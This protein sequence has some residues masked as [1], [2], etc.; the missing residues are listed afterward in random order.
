MKAF[1]I[2]L[3]LLTVSSVA[4]ADAPNKHL[5]CTEATGGACM[6]Q[7]GPCPATSSLWAAQLAD[8]T[9]SPWFDIEPTVIDSMT[10]EKER[11]CIDY[12]DSI[13]AGITCDAGAAYMLDPD[14]ALP[15]YLYVGVPT[16][17]TGAE[18]LIDASFPPG[19]DGH[20]GW[21]SNSPWVGLCLD[22]PNSAD[23]NHEGPTEP[24]GCMRVSLLPGIGSQAEWV[25]FPRRASWDAY[26]LCYG[27]PPCANGNDQQSLAV[28]PTP[29]SGSCCTPALMLL[30]NQNGFSASQWQISIGQQLPGV[31]PTVSVEDAADYSSG[32]PGGAFPGESTDTTVDAGMVP[33]AAAMP[34]PPSSNT[35]CGVSPGSSSSPWP[36]ALVLGL[37]VAR[38]RL[39]RR[40]SGVVRNVGPERRS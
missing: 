6:A 40:W 39:L 36:S 26:Q 24:V 34:M 12:F 15:G 33:A 11:N 37:V 28:Q 30:E 35:Q 19:L 3:A 14:A 22:A 16:T 17:G 25:E 9:E 23:P 27:A 18:K 7:P 38:R 20:F 2:A 5:C 4:S 1:A 32:M 29:G 13:D 21:Q 31:P 8:L 10:G